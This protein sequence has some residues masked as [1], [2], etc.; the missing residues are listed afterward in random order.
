MSSSG[1]IL[2]FLKLFFSTLSSYRILLNESYHLFDDS[3]LNVGLL[4]QRLLQDNKPYLI[5]RQ[6]SCFL[7]Q[8]FT[9]SSSSFLH[10]QKV[11]TFTVSV[12]RNVLSERSQLHLHPS[13]SFILF[14]SIIYYLWT[15]VMP[16]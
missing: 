11:S 16:L 2:L 6:Q 3:L 1:F 13:F 4:P 14:F 7:L 15:M 5:K 8:S 12:N 10:S 9:F